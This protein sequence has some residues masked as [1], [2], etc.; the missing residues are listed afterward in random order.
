MIT[1]GELGRTRTSSAG[2][3]WIAGEQLVGRGVEG[4]A[5]VD[6]EGAEPLVE[7]AASRRP[8]D[9]G[10]APRSARPAAAR[11]ALGDLL[12][13][14]GDVELRDLAGAVEERHRGLGLVGVDVDLER[15]LV[16]DDQD[17]VAELL[18]RGDERAARRGPMPVTMKL[19]Q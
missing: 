16:A 1:F 18:E 2:T 6:D 7:L 13:H 10:D 3:S 4:L 12:A 19:V 11:V 15:R 17:R 8:R 14:V 5:A 9:H